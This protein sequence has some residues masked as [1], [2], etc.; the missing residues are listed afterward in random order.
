MKQE[1]RVTSKITLLLLVW[2]ITFTA[3]TKVDPSMPNPLRKTL[4]N[5]TTTTDEVTDES[6]DII[7]L[8][9]CPVKQ[10]NTA[11]NPYHGWVSILGLG[12]VEQEVNFPNACTYRLDVSAKSDNGKPCYVSLKIDGVEQGKLSVDA[13]FFKMYSLVAYVPYGMHTVRLEMTNLR[14]VYL[15]LLHITNTSSETPPVSTLTPKELEWPTLTAENFACGRLRGLNLATKQSYTDQDLADLKLAGVNVVRYL[16]EPN[17]NLS[18]ADKL[19]QWAYENNI[20][21]VLGVEAQKEIYDNQQPIIDLWK[22]L[23]QRYEGKTH[24]AFDLLNEPFDNYRYTRIIQLTKT[25]IEQIRL[26]DA[27]R[28]VIVEPTWGNE[29]LEMMLPLPYNNLVYSAHFYE[30]HQITHQGIEYAERVSYPNAGFDKAKLSEKLQ[31]LRRFAAWG[32]PL[33]IS[34]FSCVSWAPKNDNGVYSSTQYV[35]DVIELVNVEKWAW[36]YHSFREYEGWDSEI[37]PSFWEQFPYI[38][39]TPQYD[40]VHTH[41]ARTSDAPTMNILRQAFQ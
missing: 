5:N 9:D 15:G 30:P 40:G 35:S 19:V 13:S 37:P 10:G 28:V 3:C 7:Q 39:G 38:N 1:T 31:P 22:Q 20:Y 14:M 18:F 41:T 17:S 27:A 6:T 23:A 2:L 21:V 26:I 16:I 32:V 25:L 12:Y 34:E 36:T 8:M 11:T 29:M 33:Y 4:T 24:V